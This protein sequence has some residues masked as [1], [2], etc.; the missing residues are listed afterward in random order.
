MRGLGGMS[1]GENAVQ[2]KS[3]A[4]LT[5]AV[6]GADAVSVFTGGNDYRVT[7]GLNERAVCAKRCAVKFVG[8]ETLTIRQENLQN[9]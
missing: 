4:G 5:N 8:T 3:G 1:M 6:R 9:A 7:R 2:T